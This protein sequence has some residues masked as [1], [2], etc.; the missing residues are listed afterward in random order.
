MDP[1]LNGLHI[2]LLISDGFD[3]LAL[4]GLKAVLE[5]EGAI[6][7]VLS[8]RRGTVQGLGEGSRTVEIDA[9]VPFTEADQNDFDGI[10]LAGSGPG[11]QAMEQGMKRMNEAHPFV[12][13]IHEQGKPI[14]V[15]GNGACL[16]AAAVPGAGKT[17]AAAPALQQAMQDSGVNCTDRDMV[18][19]GNW[20]SFPQWEGLPAH[21]EEMVRLLTGRMNAN[22]E[23]KSDQHAVGIAS[24]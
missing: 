19:D 21:E 20:I 8:N 22:L 14:V 17:V 12:R 15:I 4:L 11:E 23:G 7:K 5:K 2:A 13:G 3:A 6:T 18:V 16:L 10:V 24:S 9:D 1:A